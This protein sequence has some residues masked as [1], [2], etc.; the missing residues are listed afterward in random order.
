MLQKPLDDAEQV[1]AAIMGNR[2]VVSMLS[3]LVTFAG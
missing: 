1:Q 2:L 3:K